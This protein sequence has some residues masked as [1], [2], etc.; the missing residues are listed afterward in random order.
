[1]FVLS[2]MLRPVAPSDVAAARSKSMII[3]P[4]TGFM[5]LE[6]LM[7]VALLA[8]PVGLALLGYEGIQ[9]Q[10]RDESTLFEMAEI[11]KALLQFRRD[12]GTN[13]FPGQGQYACNNNDVLGNAK[14][15]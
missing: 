1:M 5:L 14:E 15:Q 2:K 12:S 11:R 13:D 4:Q 7:V 6:L 3:R 8:V 9:E 10:G